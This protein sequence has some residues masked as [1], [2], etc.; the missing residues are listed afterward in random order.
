MFGWLKTALSPRD[1][2]PQS[3]NPAAMPAGDVAGYDDLIARGNR[4]L[5]DSRWSD[6][7]AA[8]RQAAALRPDQATPLVNLAYALMEEGLAD[9][10]GRILEE[11]L[12]LQPGHADAL[13]MLGMIALQMNEL[14]NAIDHFGAAFEA[15]P[16]FEDACRALCRTLYRSGRLEEA[17]GIAEQ[18][19]ASLPAAADLHCYLGNL[20]VACRNFAAAVPCFRQ[21]IV[22]RPAYAEAYSGLG[23]AF[24][25][26]ERLGEAEECCQHAIGLQPGL[27][28]AHLNL[29]VVLKARRQLDRAMDCYRT[30]L[31]L[32]PA[33]AEAYSQLSL[34]L[35]ERGR[36]TEAEENCRHALTLRPG[37]AE[38][39]RI[40][41]SICQ[42]RGNFDA[43]IRHYREALAI[44]ANS[45]TGHN[46]LACA[47]Q[48][49]GRLDEAIDI[50]RHALKLDPHSVETHNNL[51]S[52]LQ[53]HGRL[54]EAMLS[55]R[56]ALDLRPDCEEARSN[57]LFVMSYHLPHDPAAYL[58]EAREYGRT[59]S[60]RARP[61]S[62][63]K[64]DGRDEDPQTL[65]IGLVSGDLH[66]H[67]V[68]HFLESILPHL[69]ARR[70]SL[71]AYPTITG[72]D[73]LT[74]R[75]RPRF[76][77]WKPL[78]GLDDASAAHL[79]HDDG[80]HILMDLSGHT[81]HNRLP[82]FAWKPAPLQASWLGYF[83]S[84][85]VAEIDYL[86]ADPY[87]VP[88][89]EQGRFTERIWHLPDTRLCFTP[90]AEPLSVSPLPALRNGHI[91][92]GCF[93][94]LTKIDDAVLAAWAEILTR[95][96][97]AR[98]RLQN[99]QFNSE[100]VRATLLDRLANIGIE[101]GRVA[102]YGQMPRRDYLAAHAEVD[103]LLDTFPYPGGTTTCEALWMGVPTLTLAG[104]SLLERQG[105][106]MMACAGLAGWIASDVQEYVSRA[107]AHAADLDALSRLRTVL[108]EQTLASP[109]FDAP[110]F[111]ASLE[112]AWRGM[113][114]E[115][116]T[117]AM[118]SG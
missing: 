26:I 55:F 63:W 17:V 12:R 22:L 38:T 39:C 117:R 23:L 111:A 107:S 14:E 99:R 103:I 87:S 85:G 84:T 18:G 80:M 59:L 72:E 10:A 57:L 58:R 45:T 81:A 33:L 62:Q 47:L 114:R 56:K 60:A 79:I 95:L 90:P 96:P 89:A 91:T 65:K 27:A 88:A 75:I 116:R 6:A 100:V 1:R 24:R 11:A 69:D 2:Q 93:Q 29:G 71:T 98:L 113:W 52:A 92:F 64:N 46:N 83:A 115:S 54:D 94:N 13:Y 21:A 3:G 101:A 109:L 66:N 41:G 67:P 104:R 97:T 30:A 42:E 77:A 44:D 50:Y 36:L 105:A 61:F 5:D 25:G 78:A 86:L 40:I 48:K 4:L 8:Y 43:A 53:L 15:R 16:D 70:I 82:L 49:L 35:L 7:A 112:A 28:D 51:G 20:H 108:R 9:D 32:D 34:A 31:A 118:S 102:L 68:G 73:E 74:T 106:S 37:H 110:R 19:V 76:A